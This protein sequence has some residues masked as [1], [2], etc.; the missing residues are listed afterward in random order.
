MKVDAA[1]FNFGIEFFF[2]VNFQS[3]DQF[4]KSSVVFKPKSAASL[5]GAALFIICGFKTPSSVRWLHCKPT[6]NAHVLPCMLRF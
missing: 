4:N 5:S 1:N 2:C 6:Q 3:N